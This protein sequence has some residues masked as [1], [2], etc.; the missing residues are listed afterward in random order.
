MEIISKNINFLS[1]GIFKSIG[2]TWSAKF[3]ILKVLVPILLSIFLLVRILETLFKWIFMT[4]DISFDVIN[5]ITSREHKKV[6]I[7]TI[8]I[9]IIIGMYLE[10]KYNALFEIGI[11]YEDLR[12]YIIDTYNGYLG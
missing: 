7:F 11:A 4:L 8:I 2:K 9:M 6:Y 3:W 5:H 10:N 1:G 12:S